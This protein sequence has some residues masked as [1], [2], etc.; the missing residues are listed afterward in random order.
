MSISHNLSNNNVNISHHDR[1][2]YSD[3]V[4]CKV[5]RKC[6]AI[7]RKANNI[8]FSLFLKAVKSK[9]RPNGIIRN[10]REILYIGNKREKRPS[11]L[12]DIMEQKEHRRRR[13]RKKETNQAKVDIAEPL[14]PTATRNTLPRVQTMK[15]VH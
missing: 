11:D 5:G 10:E 12:S 7:T 1:Y 13:R 14:D 15:Q 9:H 3:K 6:T 4:K 2:Y 8:V